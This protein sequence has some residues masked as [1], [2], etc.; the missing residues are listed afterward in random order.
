MAEQTTAERGPQERL[1]GAVCARELMGIALWALAVALVVSLSTHSP[2]DWPTSSRRFDD[3]AHNLLGPLGAVLSFGV[4][5]VFGWSGYVI[6]VL[7]AAWGWNLFWDRPRSPMLRATPFALSAFLCASM[8][9]ILAVGREGHDAFRVLGLLGWGLRD[10]LVKWTGRFGAYLF[11]TMGV[12]GSLIL[13]FDI[14]VRQGLASLS[15]LSRRRISAP[16]QDRRSGVR[17]PSRRPVAPPPVTAGRGPEV[18]PDGETPVTVDKRAVVAP[19]MIEFSSPKIVGG[20]TQEDAEGTPSSSLP[21]G[22]AEVVYMRPPP[23]L[24]DPPPPASARRSDREFLEAARR[25]ENAIAAFGVDGK[26]TEINPGPVITR[27]D[28]EPGPG[29]KVGRISSLSDDL[30]LA[31]RVARIRIL[32]PVPGKGAVGVEVPNPTSELVVLREIVEAPVFG[33][34]EPLLT[35]ALGATTSGEPYCTDLAQLPHLLIAGATGSGKSVCIHALIV[36]LLLRA[37]PVQL[38]LIMI[39]PKRVE[40]TPYDG[41]PHLLAP[42]VTEP[43][44][45]AEALKWAMREMESRYGRMALLGVRSLDRYNAKVGAP[46][47]VPPETD[48]GSEDWRALPFIVVII[49]ELADLMLV[50]ANEIEMSFARLAQMARA[51]GIHLVVATQRPSVDVITGVIKANFTSRIAF[52]T[53]SPVDSRTILG[54]SGAEKLLGKGDMLFLPS[55]KPEPVR[56]HGAHVG[57]EDVE[58]VVDALRE[59]VSTLNALDR[60]ASFEAPED[61]DDEGLPSDTGRDK[62]FDEARQLVHRQGQASTSLLQR[63]LGIGYPRAARLMD[64]LEEAGVVA[65][66]YG[67]K[68]REVLYGDSSDLSPDD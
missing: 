10:A 60:V 2:D 13:A 27:F 50:A 30:A 7:A 26:V 65:A 58:R 38:R 4:F 61:A 49:D 45:A 55:G 67:T 11:G 42:V 19:D 1:W 23:A 32:S 16:E 29:V 14:G 37:T 59:Q 34:T 54:A 18:A 64:E 41:I 12:V 68:A 6:A 52:Q 21:E 63:R 33:E 48:E 62:L 47:F 22:D 35:L 5:Y 20:A 57:A 40:L 17:R 46:G 56:I 15:P 44:K 39:D 8:L 28:V 36:S 25:L 53:A 66:A 51:V 3:E 9:F 24:L 31:M 43:R